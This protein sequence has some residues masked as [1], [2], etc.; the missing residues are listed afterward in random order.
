MSRRL[1]F[2][3][4]A[5]VS[6][7]GLWIGWQALWFL[8]DDAHIAF[9]YVSNSVL[10]HGYVWNPPPSSPSRATRAS[11]GSSSSTWPGA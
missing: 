3:A 1:P 10:D 9:R 11:S 2:L 5:A 6:V 8:T 4:I 7:F